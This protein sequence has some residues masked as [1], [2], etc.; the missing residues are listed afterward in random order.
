MELLALKTFKAVVDAGGIKPA[1]QQLH[2]VQSN[3]TNRVQNLEQELDSKLFQ[4]VGRK[5]ELTPQGHKL[6]DYAAELLQLEQK[7]V[8]AVARQ[9]EDYFLRIG[10]PETFEA[11]HFPLALKSLKQK[12]SEIHPRIYTETSERLLADL[13]LNKLDCALMGNAPERQ[14]LTVLPVVREDLVMVMPKDEQHDDLLLVREEGC[15]Y[16]KH[17]LIWQQRHKSKEDNMVISSSEGLLGCIAAGLGYTIIGKDMVIG[18]R[19]QQSLQF[20]PVDSG[21]RYVQI[22]M[23]YRSDHPLREGIESLGQL[24]VSQ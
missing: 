13:L 4:L 23:V 8:R 11:V 18:S 1:A 14:D 16:R 15:G 17:A 5:L 6:Y 24:F 10:M 9:K 2:T 3:V 19:Y 20:Q 12:H 21:Q 7:A 22:S